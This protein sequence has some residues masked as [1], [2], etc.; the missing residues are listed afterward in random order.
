M[1]IIRTD[2][3]SALSSFFKNNP[4]VGLLGPRQCGKTTLAKQ[5]LNHYEAPKTLF[6]DCEDPRDL[7]KLQNPMLLLEDFTGLVIIDEIQRR[8]DLFA[9]LR[10]LVDNNK[11]LRFL[12]TGSA[13]R[14]L[15]AQ[16]S[17][18]LAGRIQYL[19]LCGFS[20]S[21]INN[22]NMQKLWIRGGF[23]RSFL[24]ENNQVSVQWRE[25][26]IRTFLERDIPN[27]G[28]QIPALQLRRFWTMLSHY[29]GN[30]FNASEIGRSLN[31]AD[32][33]VKRYLDILSGTFVIRQLQPWFY[34]T[35]KRLIKRPKIFFRDSGLF[36]SFI[37]VN[38]LD[39]L[40]GNPKLGASWEG[41][42]LEQV[43][44]RL[45]LKEEEV[46]FWAVHTGAELDLVFR[47]N[48][49]L[50]G[51][52]VKYNESPVPTK[53]MYSA[54]AELN[55]ERIWVIYPGKNV[56]PIDHKI[57]VLGLQQCIDLKNFAGLYK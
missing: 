43:I 15:I 27:L 41:F 8:P 40:L 46:Y 45:D 22:D 51:I 32:T 50:W 34:N 9:A 10:V 13:S 12:I 42:A 36:H 29:H 37:G 3:I 18:T 30:I 56:Y 23:P 1:E 53:S 49:K 35:K 44:L 25:S 19:E 7:S 16:S 54:I 4:V 2:K 55:L 26:F 28:I 21:E 24:A 52:E 17:E 39:Q 57:T 33:T 31:L 6:F 11:S 47:K 5:F 38:S 48:G 20:L 14:D